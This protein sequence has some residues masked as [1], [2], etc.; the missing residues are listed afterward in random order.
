MSNLM[1]EVDARTRLAG[2]NTMELLLFHLGDGELFGI[3]VFKVR[4]VM[5]MPPLTRMPEVSPCIEGVSNIRGQ[6]VPVIGLRKALGL[7]DLSE[8]GA[9]KVIIAEYNKS[10]QGLHVAGVDRIIRLSWD[11]VKPPPPLLRNNAGGAVTAV[12]ILED[13]RMVLILDVEKIL[14]DLCPQPDE[15]AFA[16]VRTQTSLK[17][18]RVLFADDSAVARKQITKTLERLGLSYIQATTGKEAWEQLEALAAQAKAEGRA[19]RDEL[20]MILTDIEMPEMD[21][22]TLAKQISS[23]HRFGGIPI[24]MHSSLTGTCNAEKGKAVGATDYITKFDPK[25]LAETILRYC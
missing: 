6:T 16:G 11:Q 4:E 13:D 12:T 19:V 17:A 22:F 3:N 20:Q 25:M 9:G 23:D 1:N 18:K 8:A 14:A 24:I 2:A 21:G 10:L 5:K 15:E 7:G